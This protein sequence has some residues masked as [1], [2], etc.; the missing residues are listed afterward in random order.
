[1]RHAYCLTPYLTR[2]TVEQNTIALSALP[3]DSSMLLL[4][5]FVIQPHSAG[6]HRLAMLELIGDVPMLN[7]KGERVRQDLTVEFAPP[8]PTAMPIVPPAILSAL[9][10]ITI[11]QMQETAWKSLDKG[12]VMDATRRLETMATRLLDLGEHQLARAALLEA[13]RL[14]RS[15]HLSPAGRKA[16]KYGTRSLSLAPQERHHD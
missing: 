1:L 5:E 4:M 13:G 16:I 7:R 14:A 9:A 6:M 8:S 2:L 10:K 3:T 15:G 11:F 12:D